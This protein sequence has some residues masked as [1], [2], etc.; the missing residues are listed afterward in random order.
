VSFGVAAGALALAAVVAVLW[1]PGRIGTPPT[2]T[3]AA[4]KR[5]T[6]DSTDSASQPA[7]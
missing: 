4:A 7:R 1:L 6:A 5:S 3:D 2:G